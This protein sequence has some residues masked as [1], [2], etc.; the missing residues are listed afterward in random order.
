MHTRRSGWVPTASRTRADGSELTWIDLNYYHN[1]AI[2][3]MSQLPGADSK[4]G[5]YSAQA[6]AIV[7]IWSAFSRI[8]ATGSP[9]DALAYRPHAR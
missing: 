1:F 7:P 5:P 8:I 6:I 9:I 2:G 3:F 4:S